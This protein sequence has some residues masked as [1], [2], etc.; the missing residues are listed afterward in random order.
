MTDPD[1]EYVLRQMK[2]RISDVR[3]ALRKLDHLTDVVLREAEADDPTWVALAGASL[4][5]RNLHLSTEAGARHATSLLLMVDESI[6]AK[7]DYD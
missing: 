1:P 4:A 5:V 6:K 2:N 3:Q 7:P